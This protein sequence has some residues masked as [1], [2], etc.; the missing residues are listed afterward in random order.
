MRYLLIALSVLFMPLTAARADVS[1]SVGVA[2]PGV[3][4]GINVPAYPRLVRVP[5]YPVYY[6]P[7]IHLNL[8]FYDGLYWV[9]QGDRWYVS[10]WYNG[11]WDLVDPYDVPVYILR[12]PVRYYRVPPPYFRGW[13]PDGPPRWDEHWG[14]EWKERRRD[15]DRDRR[16]PPPPAPRPSYQR[17]YSGDRYPHEIQRQEMIR[18]ERYRYEP[19]E[20]VSQKHFRMERER[21]GPQGRGEGKGNGRGD[22]GPDRR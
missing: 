18:S 19:R 5:G 14:R 7:R 21:G 13:R 9:F 6:D 17:S 16:P 8:F 11:P 12:V 2:I 1:V 4:I 3:S 22:H 20:P 10:S 15:W